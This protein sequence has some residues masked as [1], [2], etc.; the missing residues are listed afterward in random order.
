MLCFF[1][2][3]TKE[4][5]VKRVIFI[6]IAVADLTATNCMPEPSQT[7]SVERTSWC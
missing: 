2:Q 6:L 1:P 3:S 5:T 4:A 7:N